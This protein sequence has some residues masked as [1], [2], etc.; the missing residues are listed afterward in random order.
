MAGKVGDA[1][2]ITSV[3]PKSWDGAV[4][5]EPADDEWVVFRIYRHSAST[6]KCII[7]KP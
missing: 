3:D 5:E 4:G 2:N 1:T 7:Q 6:G